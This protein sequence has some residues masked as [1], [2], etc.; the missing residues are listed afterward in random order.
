MKDRRFVEEDTASM[1]RAS[2]RQLVWVEIIK[3]RPALDFFGEVV[4]NIYNRRRH[5]KN[6]RLGRQIWKSISLAYASRQRRLGRHAETR[7]LKLQSRDAD[8]LE[9]EERSTYYE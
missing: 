9:R 3:T 6:D 4:Q 8:P 1:D 5:E 7:R 2:E